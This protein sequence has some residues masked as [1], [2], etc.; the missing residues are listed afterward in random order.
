MKKSS[1]IKPLSGVN[2]L[3]ARNVRTEFEQDGMPRRN[4]CRS[5]GKGNPTHSGAL[6]LIAAEA[7]DRLRRPRKRES[8]RHMRRNRQKAENAVTEFALHT[9]DELSREER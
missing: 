6:K 7:A 4:V 3:T 5:T 9:V 8:V 1:P 2:I